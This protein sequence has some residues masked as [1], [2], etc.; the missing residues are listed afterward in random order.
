MLAVVLVF[1]AAFAPFAG[2]ASIIG[3]AL[4]YLRLA[5]ASFAG[6]FFAPFI[7]CK[8]KLATAKPAP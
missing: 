3:S 5:A 2:N 7:F 1:N 6:M 8:L 4:D